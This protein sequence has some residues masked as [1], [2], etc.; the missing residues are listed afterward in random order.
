[1]MHFINASF[2]FVVKRLVLLFRQATAFFQWAEAHAPGCSCHAPP[3]PVV[4]RSIIRRPFIRR[5]LPRRNLLDD[6]LLA[7]RLSTLDVFIGQGCTDVRVS[8]SS[9]RCPEML[10]G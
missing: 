1:M 6:E 5:M 3:T 7:L 4:E 2:K 8:G 9:F 10:V